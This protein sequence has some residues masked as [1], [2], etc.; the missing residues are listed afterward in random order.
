[1]EGVS[2]TSIAE[3][4]LLLADGKK[5]GVESGALLLVGLFAFITQLGVKVVPTTKLFAVFPELGQKGDRAAVHK[6]G[7]S[8]IVN[9][10]GK[11]F[12]DFGDLLALAQD[13]LHSN[14]PRDGE[15]NHAGAVAISR[16]HA[17]SLV[18]GR[19]LVPRDLD[20]FVLQHGAYIL[21]TDNVAF[22]PSFRFTARD[23]GLQP[24]D[25]ITDIATTITTVAKRLGQKSQKSK[26][27]F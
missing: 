17:N 22:L 26:N 8:F 21:P 15:V 19:A 12:G 9:F 18:K 13:L 6:A 5:C 10:M 20:L 16:I 7:D 11:L 23:L 3:L 4:Q 14:C 24:K 2:C 25:I 27:N 1:M